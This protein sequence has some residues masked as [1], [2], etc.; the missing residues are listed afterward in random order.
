ME[1]AAV[2]LKLA[3]GDAALGW[4]M[5]V[6]S[7]ARGLTPG[8]QLASA[9]AAQNFLAWGWASVAAGLAALALAV[10]AA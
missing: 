1:M 5:Y 4:A 9:V 2:L 3:L 7:Q 6:L 8:A 10:A